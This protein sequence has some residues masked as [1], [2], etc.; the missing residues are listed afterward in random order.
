[1]YIYILFI[2]YF[3]SFL[4]S[5]NMFCISIKVTL[6]SRGAK[7]LSVD[8]SDGECFASVRMFL[9]QHTFQRI[10]IKRPTRVKGPTRVRVKSENKYVPHALEI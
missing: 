9:T 3:I 5:W 1:M 8:D 2:Y 6:N 10:C 4:N 7:A